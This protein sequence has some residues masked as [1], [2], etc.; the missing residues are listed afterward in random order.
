MPNGS[1]SA[2][3]QVL[4]AGPNDMI[5]MKE[6]TGRLIDQADIDELKAI[7]R[8]RRRLNRR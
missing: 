3:L 6:A 1:T 8:L 7:K 2:G 5:A 4:V